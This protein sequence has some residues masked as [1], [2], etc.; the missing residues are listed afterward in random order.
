MASVFRGKTLWELSAALL[1]YFIMTLTQKDLE[2]VLELACLEVP[3]Q[4]KNLYL[5]QLQKILDDMERLNQIDLREISPTSYTHE[6]ETF[7]REDRVV[8]PSDL[9]CENN[10]PEWD[11]GFF[12]VPKILEE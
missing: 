10:A 12:R 1:Y 8:Y 5:D 6:Q 9:N 11:S 7:L 4:E 2:N 3:Q